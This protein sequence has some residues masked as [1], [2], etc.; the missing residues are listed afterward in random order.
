VASNRCVGRRRRS[1]GPS[2]LRRARLGATSRRSKGSAVSVYQRHYIKMVTERL[3]KIPGGPNRS[4]S[5]VRHTSLGYDVHAAAGDACPS[6][7][8]AEVTFHWPGNRQRTRVHPSFRVLYD[9]AKGRPSMPVKAGLSQ[10]KSGDD[11]LRAVRQGGKRDR[12]TL[13]LETGQRISTTALEN[14]AT[15]EDVRRTVRHAALWTRWLHDSRRCMP[16]KAAALVVDDG[17]MRDMPRCVVWQ[18]I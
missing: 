11:A 17:Q 15:L 10:T 8:P 16:M 5:L 2:G 3:H 4:N 12:L 14:S 6:A 7:M 13:Y 1:P 9:D 18:P